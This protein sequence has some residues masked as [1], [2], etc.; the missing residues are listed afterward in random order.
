M[1]ILCF[2]WFILKNNIMEDKLITL[3]T[4]TYSKAEILKSVLESEGIMAELYN[5]NVIQP[6]VA[7][8]VKVK[9]NEKDLPRALE[10]VTNGSWLKEDDDTQENKNVLVPVDFSDQSLMACCFAFDYAA[11]IG[12][13]VYLLHVFFPPVYSSML[14]FENEV[15]TIQEYRMV[16]DSVKEKMADLVGKINKMIENKELPDTSFKDKIYEGVA[17]EEILHFASKKKSSLIVMGTRNKDPENKKVLGSVAAE[18]MERASTTVVAIPEDTPYLRFS[19]MKRIAFMT[20]LD[21]RDLISFDSLYDIVKVNGAEVILIHI[22]DENNDWSKVKLSGFKQY[23]NDKYPDLKVEI[24]MMMDDGNLT[25]I[26]NLIKE[27]GIDAISMTKYRRTLF[28]RM[29]TP[30]MTKRVFFKLD[31]PLIVFNKK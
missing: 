15:N 6:F 9:I 20:N 26:D 13:E 27:M 1:E 7:S 22:A 23:L 10:I 3:V 11:S 2:I 17:E 8:G 5:I 30:S 29:M 21:K 25:G 24:K 12:A 14:P 18:V 31:T 28:S 4:L 19:G 16:L